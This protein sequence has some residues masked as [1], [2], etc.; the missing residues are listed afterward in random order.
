MYKN[1][2]SLIN[3]SESLPTHLEKIFPCIPRASVY[4][5]DIAM[6]DQEYTHWYE[7][8]EL[9]QDLVKITKEYDKLKGTRD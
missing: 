3:L 6:M 7:L 5:K 2:K 1:L 8:F 9:A 4:V